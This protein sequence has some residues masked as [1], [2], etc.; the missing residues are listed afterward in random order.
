MR[1]HILPGGCTPAP[2]KLFKWAVARILRRSWEKV[3]AVFQWRK[4]Q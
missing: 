3:W 1:H 4:E 2:D